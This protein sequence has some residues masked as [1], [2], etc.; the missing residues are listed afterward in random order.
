[1]SQA[2]KYPRSDLR[3]RT[4]IAFY[5]AL[6]FSYSESLLSP[7]WQRNKRGHFLLRVKFQQYD[8]IPIGAPNDDLISL[9]IIDAE[10]AALNRRC[11]IDRHLFLHQPNDDF[12]QTLCVRQ[13]YHDVILHS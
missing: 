13:F 7:H 2:T 8:V 1:M 3:C 10:N 5:K 4:A 9:F 11:R 12:G 6:L